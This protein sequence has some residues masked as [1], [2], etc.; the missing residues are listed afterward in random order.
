MVAIHGDERTMNILSQARLIGVDPESRD[1]TGK[2]AQEYFEERCEDSVPDVVKGAFTMLLGTTTTR[3]ESQDDD[4]S[5]HEVFHD[6]IE[7]V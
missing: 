4:G 6:A 7:E 1:S 3:R 2:T 5:I